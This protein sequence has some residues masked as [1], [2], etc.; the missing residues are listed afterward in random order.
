MVI[1]Y[2]CGSIPTIQAYDTAFGYEIVTIIN[3]GIKRMFHD[4]EA[5]YYYLTLGNENYAMPAMPDGAE[6]GIL[7]GI[8]S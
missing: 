7:K 5:I 3:D 6:S 1:V 2:Y 4:D 8:Y